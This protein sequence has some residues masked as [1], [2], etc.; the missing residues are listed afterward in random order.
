MLLLTAVLLFAS[1]GERQAASTSGA[2]INGAIA[3]L[4]SLEIPRGA[5]PAVFESLRD[6]LR[7]ALIA[8]GDGKLVATPPTGSVNAIPDLAITDNGNGT[9][10]YAWHYYNVGDYNQDGTVGI[11]DITPLAIHFNQTWSKAVQAEVNTLQAVADGSNSEKVDI[12]DVTPIAMNFGVQVSAYR[13]E[14]CATE[15]GTYTE[16]QI[17]PLS[18]GLD[19]E[20]ARMRFSIDITPEAGMWYRLVPVDSD[21]NGGEASNAMQP[22]SAETVW[23]HTWGEADEDK[24]NAVAIDN[25]G[26]TF[27]AGSSMSST[28]NSESL[29]LKYGPDGTL[30]WR[31]TWGGTNIDIAQGVATD[32]DG[33]A[34]VTGKT[35]S[36]D[37]KYLVFILKYSPSGTLLWQKMWGGDKYCGGTAIALY[38]PNTLY[39]AGYLQNTTGKE[40]VLLLKYDADGNYQD[41]RSLSVA[42][43]DMRADAI[44]LSTTGEIF[45]AGRSR[46]N[47]QEGDDILAVK[48]ASDL[49]LLWQKQ[50][51]ETSTDFGYGIRPDSSGNVYVA[52]M[53]AN[54]GAG[55]YDAILLK[56]DTNGSL[57][58]QETWGGTTHD[59]VYGMASDADDN[60]YITGH[61]YSY[62]AMI[63]GFVV[64]FAT[65]GTRT[66][67][68]VW[69]GASQEDKFRAI[70]LYPDGKLAIAGWNPGAPGIWRDASD[71]V[72]QNQAM[73][74]FD[75]TGVEAV[76]VGAD[77]IPAGI[78]GTPTGILDTGGGGLDILLLQAD[79]SGW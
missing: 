25:D 5:N 79:P 65:N 31:K 39:V 23:S 45:L 37:D 28:S 71:A 20:T 52:G 75:A 10:N 76:L 64:K 41:R 43:R 29:I 6:A 55:G 48:Y 16:V 77:A 36:F 26:N 63:D 24:A 32:A 50:C 11:A 13:L 44:A 19:K 40:A 34:Y 17:I 73:P 18:E 69:G 68:K 53:T 74:F 59:E 35:S 38:G 61:T 47:P 42:G 62:G 60:L 46:N 51:G 4:D 2:S 7:D 27:V 57:L 54:V 70:A 8:R 49:T 21:G 66:W 56:L 78:E 30:L 3:E 1:C 15:N 22:P 72:T 9:F 33:N 67:A 12:S 14:K 58:W